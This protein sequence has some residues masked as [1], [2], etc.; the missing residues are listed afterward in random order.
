LP[1]PDELLIAFPRALQPGYLWAFSLGDGRTNI[2]IGMLV[3]A[4]S[5]PKTPVKAL[6]EQ[7]LMNPPRWLAPYCLPQTAPPH[8]LGHLLPLA[9]TGATIVADNACLIGDAACLIY[10]ATGEGIGNAILSGRLA[11]EQIR[12]LLEDSKPLTEANLRPYQHA[13]YHT[14]MP[15][16]HRHTRAVSLAGRAPWLLDGVIAAANVFPALRKKLQAF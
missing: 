5:R 12:A 4:R 2:G 14:I 15:D 16:V 9:R 1:T 13:L 3:E 10:P 6:A 7:L 11:G 8:W